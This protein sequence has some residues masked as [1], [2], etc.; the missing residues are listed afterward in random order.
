MS[1]SMALRTECNFLY[2]L[3]QRRQNRQKP[4]LSVLSVRLQGKREK[5]LCPIECLS[6]MR[7]SA[8]G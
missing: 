4:L 3:K 1:K 8:T 5:S 6:T 7:I 2:A